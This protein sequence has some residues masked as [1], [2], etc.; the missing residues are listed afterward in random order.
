MSKNSLTQGQKAP[1]FCLPDQNG[2]EICLKDFQGQWLVLYFY[3][4]DNTPGCTLE[5][6]EFSALKD[7]F[8]A[9]NAVVIGIS[10]DSVKSH[11]NFIEKK[12]ISITLLSD[13]D[14]TVHQKYDVWRTKKNY[15][16][17]YLGTVRTTFLID[18]DGVLAKVW[19]NVRTSGHADKVLGV[20][21]E[22]NT[23]PS[24]T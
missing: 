10:K 23:E 6:Q 24:L 7:D 20:L 3:P 11:T 18:P 14:T 8:A 2:N 12:D 4:R 17:E 16:K 1:D 9:E 5:A 19:D 15:G 13:Q 21:R 22:M